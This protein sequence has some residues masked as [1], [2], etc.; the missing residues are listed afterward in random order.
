MFPVDLAF[1]IQ[2]NNSL[3]HGDHTQFPVGLHD[4]GQLVGFALT[5][6]V[7]DRMIGM[8][9]LKSCHTVLAVRCRDQLLG[10]DCF[11]CVGQLDTDL[12]LLM[13]WEDIDHTVYGAG[14]TDRMQGGQYQMSGLRCRNSYTDGLEVTHLSDQNDIGIF[15]ECRS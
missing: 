12:L 5:D 13:W 14:C 11:Q 3:I 4:A 15:T 10:Y 8:H 7:A 6:Q 1:K 2:L 9:D